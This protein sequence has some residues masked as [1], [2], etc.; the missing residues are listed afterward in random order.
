MVRIGHKSL[1]LFEANLFGRDW[2][3]ARNI[4]VKGSSK[5]LDA[6]KMTRF[7]RNQKHRCSEFQHGDLSTEI[8]RAKP[9]INLPISDN[10]SYPPGNQAAAV[11]TQSCSRGLPAPALCPFGGACHAC[12]ARVQTK[13][14]VSQPD[15]P[16]EQEADRVAEQVMAMPEPKAQRTCSS[17]DE[18]NLQTRPLADQITP[19]AQRQEEES[20][21]EEEAV[22]PKSEEGVVQRQEENPEEEEP[23]QAKSID[24]SVQRQEEPEEEKP[25]EEEEEEEPAQ[26]K[27]EEGV[28]QRQ[29]ENPEEEEEPV[30]EKHEGNPTPHLT[31]ELDAKI[32]SLRGGGAPLP[33]ATRTFFERRFGYDFSGVRIHTG[34]GAIQMSNR[35]HAQA[36][37]SGRDIYLG[38]GKYN[39]VTEP[40]KSLLAHE[41]TH[42]IQQGGEDSSVHRKD[43]TSTIGRKGCPTSLP[44]CSLKPRH[45]ALENAYNEYKRGVVEIPA[46]TNRGRDIDKYTG[47]AGAMP[48]VRKGRV[49]GGRCGPAW[50]ALFVSWCLNRAGVPN[51]I[52]GLASSVTQQGNPHRY[53]K[54]GAEC[55]IS[56]DIFFKPPGSGSGS[57][58]CY[59]SEDSGTGPHPCDKL[60]CLR[61]GHGS[62]HVGFVLSVNG[63]NMETI[64]GNVHISPNNDGIGMCRRP[65]HEAAGFLR[66]QRKPA[67]TIPFCGNHAIW[68]TPQQQYGYSVHQAGSTVPIRQNKLL[69]KASGIGGFGNKSVHSPQ[70]NGGPGGQI[71][72]LTGHGEPLPP[73][74]RDFFEPRFGRDFGNVRIHTNQQ[75]AEAA[76]ST[77]AQAFTRGWD[78]FFGQGRYSPEL[79]TGQR[80]LAHELT[81]VIQQR[82]GEGETP[83]SQQNDYIARQ[84][85]ETRSP[86]AISEFLYTVEDFMGFMA[87]VENSSLVDWVD[88]VGY[89]NSINDSVMFGRLSPYTLIPIDIKPMVEE[90]LGL[91]IALSS[92][93]V[94]T[95]FSSY[96]VIKHS[97]FWIDELLSALDP[98]REMPDLEDLIERMYIERD[99]FTVI[100]DSLVR[101][102][103]AFYLPASH[104]ESEFQRR[105]R[106]YCGIY[107][108]VHEMPL[109]GSINLGGWDKID[110][111]SIF[112]HGTTSRLKVGLPEKWI[113][114]TEFISQVIDKINVGGT[115]ILYAC[116]T[117]AIL[118]DMPNVCQ[119]RIGHHIDLDSAITNRQQYNRG[120]ARFRSFL[121]DK[122]SASNPNVIINQMAG[123]LI[124]DKQEQLKKIL[125]TCITSK[126]Q[127]LNDGGFAQQVAEGL[128]NKFVTVW[129]HYVL[130]HTSR[131]P[132]WRVH[133][134]IW[135][136]R[137][138]VGSEEPMKVPMD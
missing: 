58:P 48:V 14:E 11:F 126:N 50:C 2:N 6:K 78:I 24:K 99:W 121:S 120:W 135:S 59:V 84:E 33:P 117:G 111:L 25:P 52:G 136:A 53:F 51:N 138:P 30:Q 129:G 66:I 64:E 19:L 102:V 137:I 41:L 101:T 109:A 90:I 12:P 37:T 20:K 54:R 91:L 16:Y 70:S 80:L 22:Q 112:T 31:S 105:E 15:D 83:Q 13:L 45:K 71:R 108:C 27:S 4:T 43:D 119:G 18:D 98:L 61:R 72:A 133:H 9:S 40:G 17:C 75:A 44:V 79:Q 42:V 128:R 115:I 85:S 104:G 36:V 32:R 100:L 60:N 81:H 57:Q 55:P 93:G 123:A 38:A 49:V 73:Q 3:K 94:S 95:P 77:N 96:S 113:Y 35:L 97:I 65:I 130:G 89:R 7:V 67:A 87:A 76:Q 116:E 47:Y 29:E 124:P 1:G 28:V 118:E 103:A 39:P 125:K 122:G 34:N 63:N 56:G 86:A 92:R 5:L 82:H 68:T 106:D 110:Y 114:P 21:E 10:Q 134:P 132:L 69:P 74:V 107:H 8:S 127:L 46:C 131:N 62:G 23:V 26:A 88:W